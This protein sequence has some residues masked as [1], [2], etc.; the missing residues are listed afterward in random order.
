MG[1]APPFEIY[2][3][4]HN[5][6]NSKSLFPNFLLSGNEL[7][8]KKVQVQVTDLTEKCFV[9]MDS[10][11]RQNLILFFSVAMSLSNSSVESAFDSP[12]SLQLWYQLLRP[13][14]Q[15]AGDRG[16]AGVLQG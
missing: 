14:R 16:G 1:S 8:E 15:C 7:K 3:A 12:A 11:R 9:H 4:P 10:Q 2:N 5:T 13:N 6:R